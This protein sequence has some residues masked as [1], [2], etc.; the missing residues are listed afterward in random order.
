MERVAT[1]CENLVPLVVVV[2][3]ANEYLGVVVAYTSYLGTF[4]T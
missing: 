2:Y 4:L 3:I 1:E